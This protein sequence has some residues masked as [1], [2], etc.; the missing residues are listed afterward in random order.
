MPIGLRVRRPFT[1]KKER[2]PQGRPF[3]L[4]FRFTVYGRRSKRSSKSAILADVASQNRYSALTETMSVL[5]STL[6]FFASK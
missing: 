6:C 5:R 4:L 1:E 2:A 3:F